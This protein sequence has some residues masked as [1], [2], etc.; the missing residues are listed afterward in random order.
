[1]AVTTTHGSPDRVTILPMDLALQVAPSIGDSGLAHSHRAAH[2]PGQQQHPSPAPLARVLF[3]CGPS[4]KKAQDKKRAGA[5]RWKT[6]ALAYWMQRTHCEMSVR[7]L[8]WSDYP[9]MAQ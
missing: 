7:S 5:A 1:M 3:V 6:Y 2:V 4:A 8:I 9:H